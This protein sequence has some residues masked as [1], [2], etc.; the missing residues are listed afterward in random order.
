MECKKLNIAIDGPAGAG[1]STVARRVANSLGYTY[2]DT[3]AMYRAL[4]VL[5]MERN[6]SLDDFE[7]L[8]ALASEVKIEGREDNGVFRVWID[9][10]EITDKLREPETDRAVALLSKATPVRKVLV[11]MQQQIAKCG[12]VVME[13]RDITSVVMP[14][15]EVKVF[16]TADVN[17]R[18]RRRWQEQVNKG[19]DVSF[20]E[21]LD[22]L[23]KRDA[24]DLEREWGKLIKV[25]DAEVIDS[26][27]LSIEEVCALIINLCKEKQKCSTRL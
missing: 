1:K 5:A 22:D 3:G 8:G 2:F 24:I 10:K 9:G 13:G 6:V 16:L 11:S 14:D 17:E 4:A 12:G 23:V 21:V 18:A 27:D 25:D 19:I 20:E 7:S 15:A 26:T